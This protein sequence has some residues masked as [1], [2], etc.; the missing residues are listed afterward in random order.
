MVAGDRPVERSPHTPTLW[1]FSRDSGLAGG[2]R[3]R[4]G[5]SSRYRSEAELPGFHLDFDE[6]SRTE[7]DGESDKK[8]S[9]LPL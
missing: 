7:P 1:A 2:I 3:V 8:D 5:P 9:T 4:R 6:L